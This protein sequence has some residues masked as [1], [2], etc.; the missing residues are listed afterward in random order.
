[1]SEMEKI[2]EAITRGDGPARKRLA[3]EEWCQMMGYII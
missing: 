2:F 3:Y 1:M